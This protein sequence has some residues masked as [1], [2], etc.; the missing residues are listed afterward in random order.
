MNGPEPVFEGACK[1]RRGHRGPGLF[2]RGG[3][4]P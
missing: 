3:A 1:G 4:K 2:E